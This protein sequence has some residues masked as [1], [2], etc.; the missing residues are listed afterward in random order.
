MS[1]ITT[2][3][4][5]TWLPRRDEASQRDGRIEHKGGLTD[6]MARTGALAL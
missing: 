4:L 1:G 2:K 3:V 6:I 5:S